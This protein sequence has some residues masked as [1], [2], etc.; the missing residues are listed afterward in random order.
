MFVTGDYVDFIVEVFATRSV[1]GE[2]KFIRT[3][4]ELSSG[5]VVADCYAGYMT[6]ADPIAI[7]DGKKMVFARRDHVFVRDVPGEP[8][9]KA[10]WKL[11][12]L[13]A[14]GVES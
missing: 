12:S 9:L 10:K 11:G 5:R 6:T 2:N 4:W 8:S 1:E 3:G 14:V 13:N 7:W